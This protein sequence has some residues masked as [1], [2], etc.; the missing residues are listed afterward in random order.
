MENNE[1]KSSTTGSG[2]V[3][4]CCSGVTRREFVD[5]CFVLE[6][7]FKRLMEKFNCRAITINH[8]MGTIMPLSQ[9][10]ACLTLGLLNDAGYRA[11]TG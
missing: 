5:N 3:R 2:L 9:K 4:S 6:D 11:F 1:T 7:V 10:A 8:C